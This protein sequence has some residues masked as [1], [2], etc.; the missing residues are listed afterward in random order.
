MQWVENINQHSDVIF[1]VIS[2]DLVHRLCK[3]LTIVI[4]DLFV[5][6]PHQV[7]GFNDEFLWVSVELVGRKELDMDL[8][9]E[10]NG[11]FCKWDGGEY[12][13]PDNS[14]VDNHSIEVRMS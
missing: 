8:Q 7:Y 4:D 13:E 12:R 2:D 6:L 9:K 5:K 10:N 14:L 3:K 11:F 1:N